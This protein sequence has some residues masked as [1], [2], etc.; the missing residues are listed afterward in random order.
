VYLNESFEIIHSFPKQ[1]VLLSHDD[2]VI[3]RENELKREKYITT[4]VHPITFFT[5]RKEYVFVQFHQNTLLVWEH[6][7]VVST[8]PLE[9]KLENIF[10]TTNRIFFIFKHSL[11]VGEWKHEPST[12]LSRIQRATTTKQWVTPKQ[13]QLI[14]I[15]KGTN[16]ILPKENPFHVNDTLVPSCLA[17]ESW[18]DLATLIRSNLVSA[19][20]NDL[21]S[22][23]VLHKQDELI[24]LSLLHIKDISESDLV[25]IL[26]YYKFQRFHVLD[27]TFYTELKLTSELTRIQP[28]AVL[29]ILK[30]IHPHPIRYIPWIKMVLDSHLQQILILPEAIKLI[31]G[32]NQKLK[33]QIKVDSDLMALSG[34]IRSLVQKKGIPT[35]DSTLEYHRL[36]IPLNLVE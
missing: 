12:I 32:I 7:S 31:S 27:Y 34:S 1:D 18:T 14:D 26:E 35:K 4:F 29:N 11:Q 23:L 9:S 24:D 10:V 8:I 25:S 15:K 36:S 20:T 3:T 16:T 19:S 21:L 5:S 13:G 6:D 22:K 17:N 30:F 33:Q 28:N 2:F